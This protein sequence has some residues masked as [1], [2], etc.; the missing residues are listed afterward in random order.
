MDSGNEF[1]HIQGWGSDLDR[2]KR[3]AV[4]MERT[5]P[6]LDVPWEDPPPRQPMTV[7]VLRSIERPEYSRTFGT[8]VPPSGVSGMIRR[9][10][11][12]HSENNLRHWL[13]LVAA[14]RVNV[15]EGMAGDL[16][17]SPARAVL[18]GGGVALAAW[19]LLR[20]R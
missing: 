5:P 15:V 14:D 1:A 12:R 6:R 18:V 11:F 19:W 2:S 17:R 3:P 4:P 10:A 9:A 16:K 8:R 13:M 20:R 7:E